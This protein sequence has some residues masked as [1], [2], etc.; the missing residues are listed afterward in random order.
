MLADLFGASVEMAQADRSNESVA[1]AHRQAVAELPW[2]RARFQA[3]FRFGEVLHIKHGFP[4]TGAG[5]EYMWIAVTRW[6]EERLRG[7]LVNDPQYRPDLR[8]GQMVEIGEDGVY[9]WL[10]VHTDG[11]MEGGY[12]NRVLEQQEADDADE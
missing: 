11:Q 6:A 2:V 7:T 5:H 1:A 10:I 8:A 9:D 12:T 3:G 4:T